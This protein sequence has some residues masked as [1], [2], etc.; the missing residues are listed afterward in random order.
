M[1]NLLKTYTFNNGVEVKNRLVVA[2]M[3]HWS[4]DEHGHATAAELDFIR[5]RAK[6]FGIFIAAATAV[7]AQAAG[8]RGEPS[9]ISDE[10][11]PH[12]AK[13]AETIHSQNTLA[14]IQL[15]H[16]GKDRQP[17]SG[18]TTELVAPSADSAVQ[19]REMTVAEIKQTVADFAAAAKRAMQAGF[20]GVEIH[21]ANNYLL[22]QFFSAH[23]NQRT[24][25]YGGSLENRLRFPLEV[26]DA[27]IDAC[28]DNPKFI[29][30]YRLTPEE[31][32]EKGLTMADTFALVEALAERNIQY[33]HISLQGFYNKARRNADVNR[34]RLELIREKLHGKTVALIGVGKLN[35]T[36]K[37][38]E[39]INT[40]WVDFVAIGMGVL[41]NPDF[42]E[43]CQTGNDK[44]IRKMPDLTRSAKANQMPE[45][46]LNQFMN[47]VPK[48]L[49]II[50]NFIRKFRS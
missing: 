27:I 12:L 4:S 9:A 49:R 46:M 40:G 35:T 17:N 15:H 20:D 3:T 34:S 50:F 26:T 28:K 6:G 1:S 22:Q 25:E 24:D 19:A 7:N 47:F 8:F 42:G 31:A 11:I 5:P 14:V 41:A 2:P 39:A 32:H 23:H 18:N 16:S 13:I 29:I 36:Q 10:D 33:I 30:G 45:A 21:G 48:P 37:A 44:K 38:L 43:R